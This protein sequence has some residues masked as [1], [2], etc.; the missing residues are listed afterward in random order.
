[1]KNNFIK[2]SP[3]NFEGTSEM[4]D[5]KIKARLLISNGE[6]SK[7]YAIYYTLSKN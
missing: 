5:T 6:D 1:M 3:G 2:I 4:P 7:T